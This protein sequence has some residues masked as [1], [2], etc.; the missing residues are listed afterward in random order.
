MC[1][2]VLSEKNMSSKSTKQKPKYSQ[3]FRLKSAT[4]NDE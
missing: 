1:A 2:F 4:K 3:K